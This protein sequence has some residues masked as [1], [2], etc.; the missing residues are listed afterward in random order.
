MGAVLEMRNVALLGTVL[1]LGLAGCGNDPE[2][3][4]SARLVQTA[5][6]DSAASVRRG[7]PAA[8]PPP[9]T[10]EVLSQIL[11]PVMVVRMISRGQQALIGQV[12]TNG[13]VE[14]WSTVDD[15]T[16]SFRN[17]V[18]V[19]TRGLGA[20]LMAAS[21]PSGSQLLGS[22]NSYSRIH[23]SLDGLDQPV[24][25]TLECS[26]SRKGQQSI[27]VV[28]IS[29]Q[30]TH[31]VETCLSDGLSIQNDYWL[32]GARKMRKSRQWIGQEIGYLEIEDL[33]G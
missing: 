26:S 18:V 23:T 27:D 2:S 28:E 33:R 30:V 3:F 25:R 8:A 15:V 1:A 22:Q 4:A 17:G 10:R 19:A 7:A 13:D 16:V 20:D 14:T 12:E 32:D 6:K 29:Y 11:T 9:L 31:I 5:V 21:G 24:R